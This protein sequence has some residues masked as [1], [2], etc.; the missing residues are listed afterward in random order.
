MS[1]DINKIR[2]HKT[3]KNGTLIRLAI[4]MEDPK[5]LIDDLDQAF[6]KIN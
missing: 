6:K 4:G 1:I 2:N 5:E 3:Y